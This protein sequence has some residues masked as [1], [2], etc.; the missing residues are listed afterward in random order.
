MSPGV[1]YDVLRI[2]LASPGDVQDE[3][4]AAQ[5][6]VNEL[7]KGL[8]EALQCRLN[9]LRWESIGPAYGRPQEIINKRVDR[10]DIFLGLLHRRWGEPTGA[11]FSSGFEEEF[12]RALERRRET[13]D[14]EIMIVFKQVEHTDDPGPQLQQVLEFKERLREEKEVLYKEVTSLEDWEDSI[15]EWLLPHF[16]NMSSSVAASFDAEHEAADEMARRPEQTTTDARPGDPPHDP[17]P[18]QVRESA[19]R[20]LDV[21]NQADITSLSELINTVDDRDI[22]RIYLMSAT[23]FRRRLTNEPLSTHDANAIYRYRETITPG[24]SELA[25][26]VRSM[27]YDTNVLVPGW[28]WYQYSTG[29]LGDILSWLVIS[30]QMA[31]VRSRA[32][33]LL[34]RAEI[35]PDDLAE[36]FWNYVSHESVENVQDALLSYLRSIA[37]PELGTEALARL[38]DDNDAFDEVKLDLT[39]TVLAIQ[40]DADAQLGEFLTD[41]V[42]DDLVLDAFMENRDSLQPETLSQAL[43]ANSPDVR[44]LAAASLLERNRLT[45]DEARSLANDNDHRIRAI[46]FRSLIEEGADV[47]ASV[48]VDD[49]EYETDLKIKQRYPSWVR[50]LGIAKWQLLRDCYRQYSF[51]ELQQAVDWAAGGPQAYYVLATDHFEAFQDQLREDL[52][53]DFERVRVEALEDLEADHGR[54]AREF[55]EERRDPE[56]DDFLRLQFSASALAGLAEHGEEGDLDYG[57]EFI[58]A[59]YD[60]VVDEAVKV[61]QRLG[62]EDDVDRL[63]TAARNSYGSTRRLSLQAA[64]ALSEDRDTLLGELFA[65]ED[66]GV[67]TEAIGVF[68]HHNHELEPGPLMELLVHDA[69][70]TRECALAAL[71]VDQDAE[72]LER[73]LAAYTDQETYYYDVVSWL[74]RLLYSPEALSG[75]FR[76]ELVGKLE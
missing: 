38:R 6:V 33:D 16:A 68:S 32:A 24:I 27:I 11:G 35:Q 22:A 50:D 47:R 49:L 29:E 3:R 37:N 9:L 65:L 44:L 1:K 25:L 14:P 19:E 18:P 31:Q 71:V 5:D 7:N 67:V 46:A 73:M 26:L 63:V 75:S 13:G 58:D 72:E 60:F 30:D 57:H 59:S 55:V 53:E 56:L 74:D 34:T 41:E 48:L 2:F 62:D 61:V 40:R 43:D 70:A 54:V 4:D 66:S 36:D 52:G 21:S 42:V 64:V 8:A 10:C 23:G 51:E 17:I 45:V 15:R 12:E 28:Y 76:A 39:G 69:K 20:V